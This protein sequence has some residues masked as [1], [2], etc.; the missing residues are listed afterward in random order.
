MILNVLNNHILN[1]FK[2][3]LFTN[4][5][6]LKLKIVDNKICTF[7]NC[8]EETLLNLFWECQKS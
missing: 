1:G 4:P 7:C 6:L 5:L 2:Q 8:Y 3:E